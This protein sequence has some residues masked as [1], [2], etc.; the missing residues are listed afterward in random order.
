MRQIFVDTSFFYAHAF[1]GD[2]HHRAAVEFLENAAFPLVTSNYVFDELVTI[3]RCDFGHKTAVGYGE[4]LR[5][6]KICTVAR[7]APQDEERA[8]EIF[9]KYSDQ[10]FS[11]T[12]CTSFAF[13]ERLGIKE[14]A[15]FD[16][17]F[18]IF[19]FVRLPAVPLIKT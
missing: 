9:L 2:P 14:A 3:L 18:E 19:G 1:R 13:M 11:F 8:W 15:A 4:R 5:E 12:D 16:S 17:H 10:D 7:L 6:S